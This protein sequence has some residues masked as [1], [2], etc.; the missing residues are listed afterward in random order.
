MATAAYDWRFTDE[1]GIFLE[2]AEGFLRSEPALHTVQLMIANALRTRGTTAYGEEPPHFAWL[3]DLTGRGC[4]RGGALHRPRQSGQQRVV[5]ADRVPAGTGLRHVH[6]PDG[7]P[8]CACG[9][10]HN[11]S[12]SQVS[13]VRR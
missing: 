9:Y 10:G 13:C 12:L 8:G 3:A 7:G 6:V 5:S 11:S 4:R 1:L 2:R